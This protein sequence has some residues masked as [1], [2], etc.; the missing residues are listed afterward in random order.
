MR[1]GCH[2]VLTARAS[3]DIMPY[4]VKSRPIKKAATAKRKDDHIRINLEEDVEF[5]GVTTGL[6]RLQFEHQA[7]P[8]LD[9]ARIDCSVTVFGKVL[10]APLVVSSM[11]GGTRNAQ[12][13]NRVLATAAGQAGIAMGLGS[14]RVALESQASAASFE[15][16]K[17]APQLLLFANLGAPQLN[18]GYGVEHCRRAVALAGADGLI[19][20]FNPLQEAVQPEGDTNFSGLLRKVEA[21]C[22]ALAADG[23]PVIA[24]EVGWGFSERACKQLAAAGVAAIDVA[25]AGGTSWSKVEMHRAPNP[26]LARVAAAFDDWG[27]P[28]VQALH[29]ARRGAPDTLVFASGGLRSGVDC[30]KCIALGAT[31]AGTARPFLQAAVVSEE[32]VD[33]TINEFIQQLRIS[34]FCAGAA[35]IA[36]LQRTPLQAR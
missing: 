12:R 13:I 28:T 5:R 4:I 2:I 35:D 19:L 27:I 15:L 30:A 14:M 18:Y 26:A 11:T 9:L 29:N 22:R 31:L 6:E 20:H 3:A 34:M 24:K 33:A 1:P 10:R 7:L 17:Y 8:E 23:V 21:V 25:G 36:A 32:A 16:R